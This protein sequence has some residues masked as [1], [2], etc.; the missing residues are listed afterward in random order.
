MMR[1]FAPFLLAVSLVAG[2]GLR[3][4]ARADVISVIKPNRGGAAN[5]QLGVPFAG[6]F[7]A[8]N[9]TVAML[10]GAAYG[11][12]IPL[13]PARIT[14]L[15][16]WAKSDRFDVEAKADD[17]EPTEDSE[18]DRAI[19]TA[20]AMVRSMLA[21]R[22]ALRVHEVRRDAAIFA[23][24]ATSRGTRLTPTRRDCDAI[25]KAGPFS[26][27]PVGVDAALWGPCGVRVRRGE[28]V[29]AGATMEQL[30][31]RLAPLAGIDRD[32][33]DRTGIDGRF[34]FRLQWT[35]PPAATTDAG[36]DVAGPSLF[37]TLQEQLGLKLEST[38]GPV[39]V[40]VVDRVDH[41]TPN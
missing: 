18:D 5:G 2:L 11:G 16:A 19:V 17:A 21:E 20:F 39:R 9:V 30:A 31:Q 33:V 15:P 8:T 26:G 28:I 12:V 40:L 4:G 13:G 23:L 6:K 7:R 10:I 22:F 29:A 41:P 37:T 24:V 27:P 38:R 35:P 1:L 32:V 36:A 3:I 14:G 34:D 25:A